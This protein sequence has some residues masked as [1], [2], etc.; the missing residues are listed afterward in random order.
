M[1]QSI[2]SFTYINYVINTFET[3]ISRTHFGQKTKTGQRQLVEGKTFVVGIYIV[4]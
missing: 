4:C 2:D 1:F 3:L